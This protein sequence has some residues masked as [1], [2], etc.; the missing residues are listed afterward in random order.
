MVQ[1]PVAMFPQPFWWFLLIQ[2]KTS[3]LNAWFI[4]WANF[5]RTM[6]AYALLSLFK[7]FRQGMHIYKKQWK[8]QKKLFTARIC[9]S[10]VVHLGPN[11]YREDEWLIYNNH[12]HFNKVFRMMYHFGF[13]LLAFS[14]SAPTL[15]VKRTLLF[16]CWQ[17]KP[18]VNPVR[19]R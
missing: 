1:T 15:M 13:S 2:T 12:P 9:T 7:K 8:T 10:S 19:V 3:L 18:S 4:C 11:I 6:V 17:G 14:N 16:T 5:C